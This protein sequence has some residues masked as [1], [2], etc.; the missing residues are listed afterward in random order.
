MKRIALI[1]ALALSGLVHA[2][3]LGF[4]LGSKH[5]PARSFNDANPG[6]LP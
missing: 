1:L 5:F 4:H 3:T 6:V 2:D